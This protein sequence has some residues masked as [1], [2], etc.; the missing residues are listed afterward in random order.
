MTQFKFPVHG[1]RNDDCYYCGKLG[2]HAKDFYKIKYNESK[3][4]NKRNN[5]NFVDKDTS[6]NDGFKNLKLFVFD[7]ALSV[8]IDDVNAWFIDSGA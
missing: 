6:I 8:E 3:Q 4:R 5:G 7:V 1:K 2:H